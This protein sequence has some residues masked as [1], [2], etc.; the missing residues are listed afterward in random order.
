MREGLELS[1]WIS[2]TQFNVSDFRAINVSAGS[3]GSLF[4]TINYLFDCSDLE[5]TL[6]APNRK[7]KLTFITFFAHDFIILK[8]E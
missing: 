5:K 6:R 1:L 2:F 4:Y 8:H 7:A 3:R